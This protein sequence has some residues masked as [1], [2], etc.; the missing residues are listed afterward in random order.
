MIP[1]QLVVGYRQIG[2]CHLRRVALILLRMSKS[3]FLF[4]NIPFEIATKSSSSSSLSHCFQSYRNPFG[5]QHQQQ[6]KQHRPETKQM[7]TT[8]TLQRYKKKSTL[9]TS[10]TM[11]DTFPTTKAMGE[12]VTPS[13]RAKEIEQGR[14]P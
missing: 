10:L 1:Q 7:L 4:R 3:L 5:Q 13:T 9:S 12:T 11:G 14:S 2:E 8:Q 6:R